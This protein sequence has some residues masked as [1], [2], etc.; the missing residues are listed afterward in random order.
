MHPTEWNGKNGF[1]F[2]ILNIM[3]GDGSSIVAKNSLN[4]LSCI[5]SS[6]CLTFNLEECASFASIY[7]MI[8]G[9]HL[10]VHAKD[11]RKLAGG[12]KLATKHTL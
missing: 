6:A 7:A 11:A 9:L 3:I 8:I 10:S 5:F 4:P 12:T 1:P 2:P